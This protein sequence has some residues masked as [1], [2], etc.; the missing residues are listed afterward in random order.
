MCHSHR[1]SEALPVPLS[2]AEA[3]GQM[4]M[5]GVSFPLGQPEIKLPRRPS[6]KPEEGGWVMQP[7]PPSTFHQHASNNSI[8]C[9]IALQ[10]AR[11][12]GRRHLD[13]SV[14][15][16][17]PLWAAGLWHLPWSSL[18]SSTPTSDPGGACACLHSHWSTG[19]NFPSGVDPQELWNHP[20][21]KIQTPLMPQAAR[22]RNMT[23]CQ[24]WAG[25]E[26]LW[27]LNRLIFPHSTTLA[28]VLWTWRNWTPSV[29]CVQTQ[30]LEISLKL[31]TNLI[32]RLLGGRR[33][34]I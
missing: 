13:V 3:E 9:R 20:I 30:E 8:L 16:S 19:V 21:W 23:A 6:C 26:Q 14:R 15:G 27:L 10:C 22:C 33:W 11:G 32:A 34:T 17:P 12:P 31:L 5:Y 18:C 2:N 25:T 24:G 4:L 1:R 29:G 7:P 28:R